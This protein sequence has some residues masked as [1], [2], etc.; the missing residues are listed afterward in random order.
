MCAAPLHTLRFHSDPSSGINHFISFHLGQGR[1]VGK[2]PDAGQHYHRHDYSLKIYI[3]L[4]E[5]SFHSTRQALS[6]GRGLPALGFA[7]K[8]GWERMFYIHISAQHTAQGICGPCCQPQFQ[9]LGHST[10]DRG[11]GSWRCFWDPEVTAR[12]RKVPWILPQALLPGVTEQGL[13][14]EHPELRT[15]AWSH[16]PQRAVVQRGQLCPPPRS[17]WVQPKQGSFLR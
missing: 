14:Q 1:S 2:Q 6:E 5:G 7:F 3:L 9:W 15:Q 4:T 11:T 8:C 12:G 17:T 13:T 10:H 16:C